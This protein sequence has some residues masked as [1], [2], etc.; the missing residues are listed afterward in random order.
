M[1]TNISK[2]KIPPELSKY[3]EG[4]TVDFI[5]KNNIDYYL[6]VALL[7]MTV[8]IT[9]TTAA[10]IS[11][12]IK[13][14]LY[15]KVFNHTAS[16]LHTFAFIFFIGFILYMI[17]FLGLPVSHFRNLRNPPAIFVGTD[18]YLIVYHHN[19]FM[20]L[21]WKHFSRSTIVSLTGKHRGDIIFRLYNDQT[22]IN[23]YDGTE[24]NPA[25]I[26]ISEVEHADELEKIIRKRIDMIQGE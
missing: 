16:P 26:E 7:M 17:K 21:S 10:I 22:I 4:K 11:A 24:V 2:E 15:I 25:R 20:V 6:I 13:T 9:V 19:Q 23:E 14:R 1:I 5:V 8:F 12:I 3:L 18:Q